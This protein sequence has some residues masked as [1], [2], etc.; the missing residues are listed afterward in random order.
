M[1]AYKNGIPRAVG[2]SNSIVQRQEVVGRA[3][4]D[5]PQPVLAKNPGDTL[6]GIERQDFF[7][8][9]L[10]S[11][12]TAVMASMPCIK[13]HRFEEAC[14]LMSPSIGGCRLARGKKNA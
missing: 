5:D 14:R 13:N 7:M 1:E 9:A 11:P 6:G 12:G 2:N 10:V 8:A 4:L 3:C